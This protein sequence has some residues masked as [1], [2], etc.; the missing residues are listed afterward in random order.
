[1]IRG[2]YTA[3]TGMI[4]QEAKQDV[5]ANNLANVNT[6]GFKSDNLAVKSF[7]EVLLQN[8]DKI[9]G[10][11]NVRNVI[12]SLSLGSQLDGVNTSFAQ[13]DIETTDNST[14]FAIDGAG[15]FTVKSKT[16]SDTEYK[17]TRDG[18]FA[19]NNQGYL[20]TE[21]GDYV[22]GTN[23]K[24]GTEEPLKVNNAKITTDDKSNIYLEGT[25][26]YKFKMADFNDTKALKKVGDNLYTGGVPDYSGSVTVKQSCLEKSNVNVVNEMIS[27][28]TVMRNFESDQKVIQSIDQT[29]EKTV[30][31]VG[32][33]R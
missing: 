31:E 6:T 29:L 11:K 7:D 13:G 22:M 15:F 26:T 9:S 24:S 3:V 32:A 18:K 25:L 2:I 5:I 30:N 19:V 14:D 12:G 16:A 20:V 10:G 27:M 23:L 28:M 4:T 8:Y 21:S 1:M 33:V 17:F